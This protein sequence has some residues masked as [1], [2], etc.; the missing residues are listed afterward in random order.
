MH[1]VDQPDAQLVYYLEQFLQTLISMQSLSALYA[2]GP[3]R[4]PERKWSS[5]KLIRA[6]VKLFRGILAPS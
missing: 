1:N 6:N 3:Q 4:P 2:G 5:A